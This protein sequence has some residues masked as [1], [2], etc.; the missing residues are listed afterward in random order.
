MLALTARYPAISC[1]SVGVAAVLVDDA[2]RE[3]GGLPDPA[4]GTFDAAG[5][6]DRLLGDPR[7]GHLQM[8]T[9]ID[10]YG[11]TELSPGQAALASPGASRRLRS[12]SSGR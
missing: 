3:R 11:Q 8:W 1:I 2:G 4:G 5:D 6:F 10:V 9:S 12:V 7:T